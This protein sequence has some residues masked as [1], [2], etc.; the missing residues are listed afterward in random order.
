LVSINKTD[1]SQAW[2]NINTAK[3]N[4]SG[5]QAAGQ[6]NSAWPSLYD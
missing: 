4:H 1:L 6:V 5:T 2:I 3:L